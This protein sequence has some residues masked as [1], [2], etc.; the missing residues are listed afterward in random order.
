MNIALDCVPCFVR[1]ALEAARFASSDVAVH[2]R[3]LRE[4][5][6]EAAQWDLCK[7]AP[8]LSQ[9]VQRRL[10]VLTEVTDPYREVKRRFNELALE[11]LPDFRAKVA[12]EE[13]PLELAARIAIAGNVID[14]GANGGLREPDV[15]LALSRA[16]SDP[17]AGDLA[18]F[19]EQAAAA[20]RILYLADNAGEIVFDRLLVEQLPAGRVTVAVRGAPVLNDAT[21]PD[22]RLAGLDQVAELIDNGSDAPGTVL[23]ECSASFREYFQ[24]AD[25][26]V[27]K[28]QGNFE[29]LNGTPGNIFFLLKIKCPVVAAHTGLE[30]GTLALLGP[31]DARNCDVHYT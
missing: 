13:D 10:R 14:L 5:L 21:L 8:V 18:S 9:F 30:I 26:I 25:M 17:F 12:E 19:R 6:R 15:R 31:R 3:I 28:G 11:L 27:A 7:P 23:D 20:K 1:H 16:L 2:E 4:V 24:N 22:A 29:T